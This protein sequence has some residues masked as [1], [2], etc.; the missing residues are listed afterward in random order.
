MFFNH[1]LH[2]LIAFDFYLYNYIE[3][4]LY[5]SE[6]Q[7]YQNNNILIAFQEC[8]CASKHTSGSLLLSL[9]VYLENV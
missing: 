9:I 1:S 4:V 2:L 6:L 3:K 8:P 7:L 5:L